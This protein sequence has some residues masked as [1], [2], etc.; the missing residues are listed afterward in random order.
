MPQH[1]VKYHHS[2]LIPGLELGHLKVREFDFGRHCHGDHHIGLI[3][4]GGLR[5]YQKGANHSLGPGM[6]A[7]TNPDELHYGQDLARDGFELRVFGI[8]PD[9]A[10]QLQPLWGV[11]STT[12]NFNQPV[13][14]NPQLFQDLVSFHRTVTNPDADPLWVQSRWLEL[15]QQL[16]SGTDS[17]QLPSDHSGLSTQ[18][19]NIIRDYCLAN[20]DRKISLTELGKLLDLDQYRLLR[21][22]RKTMH[23]TPHAWLVQLRL[24]Y[25][26]QLLRSGKTSICEAAH[27]SGFCDQS[28]L[29][30]V[31]RKAYGITPSSFTR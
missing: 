29:C 11:G 14:E 20:I 16:I 12:L 10:V 27:A 13:I 3:C 7:L 18:A 15:M 17:T 31:F 9:L 19:V 22:F 5:Q 24:D 2:R 21:Q 23:F 30:R 25:A 6:I 1:Q 26:R 28:H 4:R 8:S